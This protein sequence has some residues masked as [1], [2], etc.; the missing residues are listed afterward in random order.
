MCFNTR[1]NGRIFRDF[2]KEILWKKR[3]FRVM[4]KEIIFWGV[5]TLP[6][7]PVVGLVA[8]AFQ[9]GASLLPQWPSQFY[10]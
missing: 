7:V 10:V 8:L 4:E 3:K 6:V 9:T 5:E 1:K 2:W